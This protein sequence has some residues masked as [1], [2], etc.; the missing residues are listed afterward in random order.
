MSKQCGERAE[1]ASGLRLS[2]RLSRY[3]YDP[4][5]DRSPR[6][7]NAGDLRT[8]VRDPACHLPELWAVDVRRNAIAMDAGGGVG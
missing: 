8:H 1:V 2:A 5:G 4:R 3:V 6:Y 7:R